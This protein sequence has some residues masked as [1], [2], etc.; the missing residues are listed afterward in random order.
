MVAGVGGIFRT[1]L[2]GLV[3]QDFLIHQGGGQKGGKKVGRP[4]CNRKGVESNLN[5]SK[6]AEWDLKFFRRMRIA[7]RSG[8]DIAG[9]SWFL[10]AV[11]KTITTGKNRR[12]SGKSAGLSPGLS[13][14]SCS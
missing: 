9:T 7:R 11:L 5:R 8:K 3:S 13:V 2:P 10:S 1:N 6:G 4:G 12:G 14:P